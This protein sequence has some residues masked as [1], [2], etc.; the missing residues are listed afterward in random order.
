MLFLKKNIFLTFLILLL[1]SFNSWAQ[2]PP[3]LS[4]SGNQPYCPL[5]S[6][7]IVT[8]FD[9]SS[10]TDQ[11]DAIFIQIS[12][13]Y[14]KATDKLEYTGTNLNI[15]D[16]IFKTL[17]GKLELKWNGSG[18]AN[19]AELIAAVKNVI[20]SSTSP[21]PS[22][23]K[24]FSI[25]IDKKNYL[26]K[27]QHYYEYI[28][29]PG[30]TW[31]EA[32]DATAL[33]PPYY[34][35]LDPYLATII[36]PEEAKI[37]GEQAEGA[38]W[39]GGSDADVEGTWRWVTGPEAGKS[40][41]IGTGN[42]TTVGTD[43]SFAFWNKNN[44]PPEP[45]NANN[46]DYAH[47]VHPNLGGAEKGSWNDLRNTGDTNTGSL[48]HPQGYIVEYGGMPGN[49]ILDLAKT[50]KIYIPKLTATSTPSP[51]CG[52]GTATL[53]AT[54][55]TGFVLWFDDE[56]NR[57]DPPGDTYTTPLISQNTS[58]YAL[59]S[60]DGICETGART[61]IDVIINSLPTIQPAVTL[62]NC[63]EDGNPDSY[64]DFNL[65]EADPFITNG[66]TSLAVTYYLTYDDA[67]DDAGTTPPLNPSP[68]NNETASTVYAR[69]E[70]L[71]GC[72]RSYGFS[73]SLSNFISS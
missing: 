58:Y 40:F 63:D 14:N 9:L 29:A 28:S 60:S 31:T 49:P 12:E 68:F 32:I 71:E 53:S 6:I 64:T 25:T 34:G 43:I 48:Y 33:I 13:G 56:G 57:L 70:N 50:T 36:Y 5:S 27:T 23:D 24:T 30:I 54:S 42:G 47:V 17:E 69:A 15:K 66:D 38:G 26:P 44:N 3:E 20:F 2:I 62:K 8:D 59:A 19:D 35:L 4:A 61:K 1:F 72:H 73:R 45:N 11:V 65:T 67:D 46:E 22:N 51:I 52:S 39:I 16:E 10:G 7:P 18:T 21:S 41:W 55:N 37:C